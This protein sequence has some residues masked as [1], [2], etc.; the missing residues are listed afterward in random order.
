MSPGLRDLTRL[1]ELAPENDP[2]QVALLIQSA[3]QAPDEPLP[4]VKWRIQNTLRRRTEWN[5]RGLRLALVG[6]LGFSGRRCGR[7]DRGPLLGS[8]RSSAPPQPVVTSSPAQAVRHANRR[9]PT[10]AIPL[11]PADEPLVAVGAI[12]SSSPGSATSNE[13][14][15]GPLTQ[16]SPRRG[17]GCGDGSALSP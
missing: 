12:C 2:A 9:A 5:R 7:R 17:A 4:L 11:P 16:P 10:P 3:R 6:A 14:R 8:R 13:A 1:A 15:G